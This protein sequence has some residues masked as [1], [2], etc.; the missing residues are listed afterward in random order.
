MGDTQNFIN[1]KYRG[2]VSIAQHYSAPALNC[3]FT[4]INI[5]VN[6]I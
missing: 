5:F 2:I 4:N 3:A 1:D 6:A